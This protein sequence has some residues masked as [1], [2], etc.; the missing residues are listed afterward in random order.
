MGNKDTTKTAFVTPDG[1]YQ[2]TGRGT[3]FGLSGAAG[4]FQRLMTAILGEL[5][6]TSDYNFCGWGNKQSLLGRRAHLQV[7]VPQALRR[8][9]LQLVH[10]SPISDHRGRDC[11]IHCIRQ[12]AYRPSVAEDVR[13]YCAGCSVCQQRKRSKQP[14][15]APM[16][17]ADIP[18]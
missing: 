17:G 2:W 10:D 15:I 9:L 8:Q 4:S 6:W 7:V 12:M 13:A 5:A 16:Q 1:Q 3:P 14:P 11:T 18:G